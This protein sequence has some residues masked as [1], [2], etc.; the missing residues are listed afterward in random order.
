M[1][2]ED[3]GRVEGEVQKS[4]LDHQLL[5]MK[6][7][8]TG[9]GG[10]RLQVRMNSGCAKFEVNLQADAGSWHAIAFKT[11]QAPLISMRCVVPFI[12]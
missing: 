5:F 6:P 9:W 8:D 11:K 1:E 3:E 12:G 2:C 4:V 7:E 10:S